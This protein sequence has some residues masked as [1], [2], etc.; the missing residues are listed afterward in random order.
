M[1]HFK[2]DCECKNRCYD[3]TCACPIKDLQTKCIIYEGRE[4]LNCITT[5]RGD[6]LN[7]I[8]S[9]INKS[10]CRLYEQSDEI[11]N[12][13][14][15]AAVYKGKSE[16]GERELRTI[17]STDSTVNILQNED[18]IDLSVNIPEL[19]SIGNGEKILHEGKVRTIESDTLFIDVTEEGG[20][21]VEAEQ[22]GI[23]RYIVNNLYQ[24]SEERGTLS[25]PF[26]TIQTALNK[27]IGNGTKSEPENIGAVI[28]VQQGNTYNFTGTL[29]I[30]GLKMVIEENT[31]INSNPNS[32]WFIDTTAINES[33]K[34][35][36]E[37][38]IRSGARIDLKKN[39]IRTRGVA[40]GSDGYKRVTLKGEGVIVNAT[41]NTQYKVIDCNSED[42]SNY[43]T[44]IEG[45]DIHIQGPTIWSHRGKTIEIGGSKNTI[46]ITNSVVRAGTSDA[47]T[48]SV[49][50]FIIRKGS[51]YISNSDIYFASQD[52]RNIGIEMKNKEG[53][54][55]I[56]NSVIQPQ[57][58]VKKLVYDNSLETSTPRIIIGYTYTRYGEIEDII[59]INTPKI[60]NDLRLDVYYNNFHTGRIREEV[61]LTNWNKKSTTNIIK[62]IVIDNLI[63]FQDKSTAQSSG[64]PK[65][66]KF[67]NNQTN[68]VDMIT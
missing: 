5:N 40:T 26:K 29:D 47:T 33:K 44:G 56:I 20:L 34:T 68:T 61:D 30:R 11:V 12:V 22:E 60:K 32:G 45:G 66:T 36:I 19:E 2:N 57:N 9:N 16:T 21:K 42:N 58:K 43:E 49:T 52:T 10:I 13:G 23:E 51:L 53:R 41:N 18:T 63:R 35:D 27:L 54:L 67:I 39:G 37:V 28:V 6:T 55:Q 38:T 48:A 7:V 17:I 3:I 4:D 64:Y 59:D 31:R 50:P 25:K 65:G 1:K 15:G 24:G 62:G 14:K 46:Y 8:L